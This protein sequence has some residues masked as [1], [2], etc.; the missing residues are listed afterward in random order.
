MSQ[1]SI[2]RYLIQASEDID[3]IYQCLDLLTHTANSCNGYERENVD[4][5]H[6]MIELHRCMVDGS[7][8]ELRG[9][10]RHLKQE[11]KSESKSQKSLQ[12]L[13]TNQ[14]NRE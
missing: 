1:N 13:Q 7:L 4:R 10:I 9:T 2:S 5:V 12:T 3:F 11:C 8:E 14:I 6:L